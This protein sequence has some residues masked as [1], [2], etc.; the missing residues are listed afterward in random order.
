MSFDEETY[1]REIEK[2]AQRIGRT[3]EP[4]VQWL[5]RFESCDLNDLS[6]GELVNMMFEVACMTEYQYLAG[7]QWIRSLTWSNWYGEEQV[8]YPSSIDD[9][10]TTFQPANKS[11]SPSGQISSLR[12]SSYKLPSRDVLKEL[13]EF[14]GLHL[15]ELETAGGIVLDHRPIR[16]CIVPRPDRDENLIMRIAES[17]RSVF[18]NN[19]AFLLSE[20][21]VRLRRCQECKVM[22]YADR[23]NKQYCSVRC[24]SRAGTRRWRRTPPERRGK[25][26]RPQM[27][28]QS[29]GLKRKDSAKTQ[30]NRQ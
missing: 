9:L 2:A 19:I 11:K 25:L 5:L 29:L 30:N 15:F 16:T 7:G 14:A 21:A 1:F 4:A 8:K 23:R 3:V 17:P 6:S 22:F 10:V 12:R 24:Q 20:T 13:Q 18:E 28:K 26:G 27:V